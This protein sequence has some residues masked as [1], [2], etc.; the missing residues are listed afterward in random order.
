MNLKT[1][2]LGVGLMLSTTSLKVAAGTVAYYRFEGS[3]GSPVTTITDSGPIGLNGSNTGST[4]YSAS[5]LGTGLDL[6]GDGNY[7]TIPFSPRLVLTNDFTVELYMKA[8]QPYNVYGLDAFLIN[9]LNTANVGNSLSSY[10]IGYSAGGGLFA[11]VGYGPNLNLMSVSTLPIFGDSHWHHV[12]MVFH[13][14]S[15]VGVNRLELFVDY[16]LHTATSGLEAPI[17]WA[18]FPVFIGAANFPGGQDAGPFRRNFD[19]SI[20]EVRISD[21]ALTP[22]DFVTIPPVRFA[23]VVIPDLPGGIQLR[24]DSKAN[25]TYQVQFAPELSAGA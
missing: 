1:V 8:N 18:D 13:H 19:G 22:A 9:Q 21:V 10:F 5:V 23:L 17:V 25:Y 2:I 11:A 4:H 20:D 24:W 12:A 3:I 6:S 16:L 7:V 14:N 15:P